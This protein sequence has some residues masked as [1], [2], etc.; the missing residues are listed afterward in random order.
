ME[1]QINLANSSLLNSDLY[2]YTMGYAIQRANLH[3]KRVTFN[4]F[5]RKA[6]C[7]NGWAVV[8]GVNEVLDLVK[9]MG[10]H[11][12]EHFKKFLPEPEFDEYCELLAN[13]KFTGDIYAMREGE[14]AFPNENIITIEAPFLEAQLL[15]TPALA[16]INHQMAVATKASRVTRATK[17]SVSEFGSRR[18][19]GIW[20]GQ[21][22]GKAAY[23][24]SCTS[25]SNI[26]TNAK[27]GVPCTGTHAHSFIEFFSQLDNIVDSEFEA[28]DL[29]IKAFKPLNR[30]CIL[31]IDTFDTLNCGIQNAIK[32]FHANGIDD[33]YKGV[34]GVR[35]DSGDL[36]YQSRECRKLLNEAGFKEAKIFATNGLDEYS[37]A[38]LERRG[39]QIDCYGVG[40]AIATCK[41]DPCFG[42]V[43]KLAAVE[44]EPRIKLSSDAIKIINPGRTSTY[45]ISDSVTG[46]FLADIICLVECDQDL[47][48]ILQGKT[49]KTFDEKE[50]YKSTVLSEGTYKVKCLQHP[51]LLNGQSTGKEPHNVHQARNYYL[52]TLSRFDESYTCLNNPHPFYVNLSQALYDLKYD[53]IKG[54]HEQVNNR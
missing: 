44:G 35:L 6:P 46:Q 30:A 53:T 12:K 4:I 27:V 20:A 19:H 33:D 1:N 15:E 32:A 28:F 49:I 54:I 14:I 52:E 21:Y 47:Y 8:S 34:Y 51:F 5:F 40:D 10:K 29:F 22:G 16:I 31:L 23:I 13:M 24:G 37:I 25:T 45:R 18:A 38:E 2:Q 41:D 36:A 11:P 9:E 7:G 39:A 3:N 26:L 17:K 50:T 43:F 48:S 42:G